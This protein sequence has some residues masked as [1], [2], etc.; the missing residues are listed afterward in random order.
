MKQYHKLLRHILDNGE[1]RQNRTG[2]DTI[3]T[4]G[5]Q[6]RYDLSEGLPLLTTKKLH[7]KSIIYELLWF[8][9]GDTNVKYLQDNG[10]KIWDSWADK[11]GDLDKIYGHQWRFW[12][13]Q[14]HYGG[15]DQIANVIEEIK[16]N[17]DSR[18]LIVSAWNVSDL[19]EMALQPCHV[20]FQFNVRKG[21]YLDC[22]LYQRSADA[23]IG[24]PYN[25]ASYALL[26]MMIG[27]ITGYEAGH[28]IHS[29]GDLH[30]YEYHLEQVKEQLSRECYS[31]PTMQ[32][33]PAIT[34]ID[35]FTYGDFT[36]INYK[37]HPTIRGDVAI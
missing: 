36:L 17:P 15:I 13:T 6:N 20:M 7:L 5:Y 4:F 27:Q 10:V 34:N 23:F 21:R 29:F 37:S 28:F 9:R 12:G 11:D 33:N 30:I 3:S 22:H 14:P 35:D 2:T 19:E 26:T 1:V 24:I 32:I 16:T 31:L 25:T 8:L 18:R